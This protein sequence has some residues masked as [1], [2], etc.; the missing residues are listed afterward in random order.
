LGNNISSEVYI[1]PLPSPLPP[2]SQTHNS[3]KFSES[4]LLGIVLSGCAIGFMMIA[5]L[6]LFC[7]S[8]KER[9][10]NDG[11]KPRKGKLMKKKKRVPTETQEERDGR[12]TFFEGSTLAFDLEDLLRA[13]AEVLGKGTF[14]TTYKAALEDSTTVVVKR[15][16]EVSVG[17]RD[18][19]QLMEV[20]GNIRHE[21]VAA[22]RAYYYSKDEKLMVYDHFSR[23]SLST[24]LHGMCNS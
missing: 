7:C 15:L 11:L 24:L 5:F 13:S 6:M 8:S 2:S 16:K 9:D 14:G 1:P 19:E 10:R 12:I 18:F 20:V 22:L 23:G 4:A 21:N 17:K 3:K